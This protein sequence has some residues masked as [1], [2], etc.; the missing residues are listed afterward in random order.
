M[1]IQLTIEE[2]SDIKGLSSE[3]SGLRHSLVDNLCTII[4]RQESAWLDFLKIGAEYPDDL[5]LHKFRLLQEK[6]H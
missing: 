5:V 1:L 3:V 2:L 4:P 6:L